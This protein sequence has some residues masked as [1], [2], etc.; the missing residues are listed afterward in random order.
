LITVQ[1]RE[2][3]SESE[4]SCLIRDDATAMARMRRDVDGLRRLLAS[5][6]LAHHPHGDFVF[7]RIAQ[8]K[9]SQRISRRFG[10]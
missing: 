5:H 8:L 10:N 1:F 6:R 3:A 9:N 7:I 4:L 2:R